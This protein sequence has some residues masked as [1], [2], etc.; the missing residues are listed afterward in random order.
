M[1]MDGGPSL[2]VGY[3]S[4]TGT[5]RDRLTNQDR[6]T[7]RERARGRLITVYVVK[8]HNLDAGKGG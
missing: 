2:H 1:D 3:T 7:H 8:L 5:C 4:T 6:N